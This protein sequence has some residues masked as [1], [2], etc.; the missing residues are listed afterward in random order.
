MEGAPGMVVGLGEGAG[1]VV[2]FVDGRGRLLQLLEIVLH[3]A[4]AA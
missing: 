3:R 2:E 1:K 4:Q